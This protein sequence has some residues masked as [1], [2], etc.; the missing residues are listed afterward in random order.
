MNTIEQVKQEITNLEN[1]ISSLKDEISLKEQ[2]IDN[3]EYECSDDEYDNFLDQIYPEI[4][5]GSLTFYPS[6]VIKECDPVAY[7]CAKSDY[8][9]DYDLDECE[10]YADLKADL[11]SLQD[12]LE[13]L[14][15]DLEELENTLDDLE[16]EEN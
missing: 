14:E 10:E 16:S 9:S 12:D 13:S 3:F 2:E 15:S 4:K 6:Q 8:E 7:R 11:E 1:E 5:I